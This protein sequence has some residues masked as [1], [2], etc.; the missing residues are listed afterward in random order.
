MRILIELPDIETAVA[1]EK[2][3]NERELQ[4]AAAKITDQAAADVAKVAKQ[5]IKVPLNESGVKLA[6]KLGIPSQEWEAIPNTGK[7]K[8]P[9]L[10]DIRAYHKSSRKTVE[11]SG[12]RAGALEA[13]K[14][15]V[16]KRGVKTARELLRT[17]AVV[18]VS[19][20]KD[21]DIPKFIAKVEDTI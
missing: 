11:F 12:D 15:L 4:Q 9:T 8:Y 2:F 3:I 19:D 10:S 5:A 20:L 21:E 7:G 13:L 6:H 1:V 14:T 17:F 18:K 16:S